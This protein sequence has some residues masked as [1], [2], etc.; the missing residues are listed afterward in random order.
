MNTKILTSLVLLLVL[1][2]Q[3]CA[4]PSDEKTLAAKQ[5]VLNQKEVQRDN[6]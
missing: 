2:L 3:S 1:F 4:G 6:L 5:K